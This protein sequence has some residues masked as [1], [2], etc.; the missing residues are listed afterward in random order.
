MVTDKLESRINDVT[1]VVHHLDGVVTLHISLDLDLRGNK[2]ILRETFI[3]L[4]PESQL[5]LLAI[6]LIMAV[7]D[8]ER[9]GMHTRELLLQLGKEENKGSRRVHRCRLILEWTHHIVSLCQ[10]L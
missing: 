6:A 10:P 8:K 9:L 1:L 5:L 7:H 4:G 2:A 3:R